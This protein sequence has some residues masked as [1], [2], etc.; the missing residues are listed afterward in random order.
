MGK[1]V[2]CDI[3]FS[4]VRRKYNLNTVLTPLTLYD[5]FNRFKIIKK[6]IILYYMTSITDEKGFAINIMYIM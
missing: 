2:F 6:Y 3:P 1:M 5:E 4:S